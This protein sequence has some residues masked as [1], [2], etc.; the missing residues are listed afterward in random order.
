MNSMV[1]Q[2]HHQ[3]VQI[4]SQNLMLKQLLATSGVNVSLQIPD[5]PDI[6]S[7]TDI[8][9]SSTSNMPHPPTSKELPKNLPPKKGRKKRIGNLQEIFDVTDS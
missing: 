8:S 4:R 7:V 3:E 2:Q 5:V 1:V 9:T 6:S